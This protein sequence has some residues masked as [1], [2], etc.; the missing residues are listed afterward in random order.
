VMDGGMFGIFQCLHQVA[1]VS[2]QQPTQQ[3]TWSLL[4]LLSLTRVLMKSLCLGLVQVYE[5]TNNTMD[6]YMAPLSWRSYFV[7]LVWMMAWQ[8]YWWLE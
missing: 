5:V 2:L 1:M 7:V 8:T 4:S 3:H 6:F